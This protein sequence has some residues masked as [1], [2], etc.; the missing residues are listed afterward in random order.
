MVVEDTNRGSGSGGR[1]GFLAFVAIAVVLFFIIRVYMDYVTATG[2]A[3]KPS[4]KPVVP[5]SATIRESAFADEPVDRVEGPRNSFGEVVGRR[6]IRR[7]EAPRVEER[8]V[9]D[10]APPVHLRPAEPI[11]EVPD[12]RPMA[13][14]KT[15]PYAG[16]IIVKRSNGDRQRNP[17]AGEIVVGRSPESTVDRATVRASVRAHRTVAPRAQEDGVAQER[18]TLRQAMST[19]ERLPALFQTETPYPGPYDDIQVGDRLSEITAMDL[20][21]A[22]LSRNVYTYHPKGGPFKSIMAMLTVGPVDPVVTG[23]AYVFRSSRSNADVTQQAMDAFG[24]GEVLLTDTG[25]ERVW[26]RLAGYVVSADREKYAVEQ[27]MTAEGQ[28]QRRR[29]ES[30]TAR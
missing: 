2:Q 14:H 24:D 21:G 29:S 27:D 25:E 18:G 30:S 13:F 8:A 16:Q 10:A 4:R 1:E 7:P 3:V 19:S 9:P 17:Y 28:R 11:E 22:K 5:N 23:I 15:N 26:R 6:P 20:P 12:D